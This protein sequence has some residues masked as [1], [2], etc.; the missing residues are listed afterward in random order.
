MWRLDHVSTCWLLC[1]T[2]HCGSVLYTFSPEMEQSRAANNRFFVCDSAEKVAGKVKY[3]HTHG[4]DFYLVQVDWRNIAVKCHGC[5]L[6]YYGVRPEWLRGLR[7]ATP[8]LRSST[9]LAVENAE[10][11]GRGFFHRS[12]GFNWL[13]THPTLI[14]NSSVTPDWLYHH[15]PTMITGLYLI[16]NNSP[17]PA[18]N[19]VVGQNK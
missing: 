2:L 14:I 19:V 6:F 17:F 4:N 16:N 13:K 12:E 18:L 11:E 15:R 3:G 9:F 10:A 8:G 7:S 1:A 5:E